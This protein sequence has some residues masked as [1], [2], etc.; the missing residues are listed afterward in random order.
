MSFLKIK[1]TLYFSFFQLTITILNCMNSLLKGISIIIQNF[2]EYRNIEVHFIEILKLS[3]NKLLVL[4]VY[5]LA[6]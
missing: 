1:N 2:T 6:H 4:V 3:S 5:D